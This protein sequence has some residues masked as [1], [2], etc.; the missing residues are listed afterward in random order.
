V[1]DRS[2]HAHSSA[3]I[4]PPT[5]AWRASSADCLCG[6]RDPH[7]AW[8]HSGTSEAGLTV[9]RGIPYASPPMGEL[10]WRAPA[11]ASWKGTLEATHF[12]PACVQIGGAL[13]GSPAEKMS[14]DCLG[15]NIWTPANDGSKKLQ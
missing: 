8:R 10:R 11:P 5:T 9:Y 1:A 2:W 3:W 13:P 14:E 12:K 6:R 4:A 15:L 7:G